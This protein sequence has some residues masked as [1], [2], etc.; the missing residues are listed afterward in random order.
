MSQSKLTSATPT[1]STSPAY[2]IGDNIGG[3]ITL[4][5]AVGYP[6]TGVLQSLLICDQSGQAAA[7][8]VYF[9]GSLPTATFTDNA[10]FPALS[11]VDHA[12]VVDVVQITAANY[13]TVNG[14]STASIKGIGAVVSSETGSNGGD[15]Y[16]AIASAATPTY[17]TTLALVVKAGILWD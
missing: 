2:A 16:V 4:T 15:L 9:F 3:L 13:V 5:Q 14:K 6:R 1:V 10:A 7:L 11:A 17:A 12:K 8:N